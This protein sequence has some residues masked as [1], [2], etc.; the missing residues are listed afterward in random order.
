MVLPSVFV[1]SMLLIFLNWFYPICLVFRRHAFHE[2]GPLRDTLAVLLLALAST[3]AFYA[4]DEHV[5][6]LTA[7]G[8]ASIVHNSPK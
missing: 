7:K 8:G 2:M 6:E 1:F 5:T 4:E 3:S